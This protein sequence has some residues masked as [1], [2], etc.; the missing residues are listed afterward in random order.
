MRRFNRVGAS[1]ARDMSV[2]YH[3]TFQRIIFNYPKVNA[4]A[5]LNVEPKAFTELFQERAPGLISSH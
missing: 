1:P 5:T 3:K 4:G 2:A